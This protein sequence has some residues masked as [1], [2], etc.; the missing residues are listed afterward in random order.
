MEAIDRPFEA[1][2][3]EGELAALRA[4]V[5][6][7]GNAELAEVVVRLLQLFAI[8]LEVMRTVASEL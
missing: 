5:T 6:E 2:L 3:E 8:I 7:G 1:P 4:A